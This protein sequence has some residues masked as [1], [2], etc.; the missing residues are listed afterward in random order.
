VS[1][2]AGGGARLEV[3]VG[4]ND[5]AEGDEDGV[6]C[7]VAYGFEPGVGGNES[8]ST[9]VGVSRTCVGG[10]EPSRSPAGGGTAWGFEVGV[11][12]KE[13]SVT[14]GTKSGDGTEVGRIGGDTA[15]VLI[16]GNEPDISLTTG[17]EAEVGRDTGGKAVG[18]IVG[19]GTAL[20][21][22][23]TS[24]GGWASSSC[25][26]HSAEG[27]IVGRGTGLGVEADDVTDSGV[28]TEGRR[29]GRGRVHTDTGSTL[30]FVVINLPLKSTKRFTDGAEEGEHD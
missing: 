18:L 22:T 28:A 27:L 16:G 25:S 14:T 4:G 29:D 9:S 10:N 3:G 17:T 8:S 5:S 26:D 7:N 6:D 20:V 23:G 13:P 11:G 15:I 21:V 2:E 1:T 24:Q 19:R 12:G 30:M